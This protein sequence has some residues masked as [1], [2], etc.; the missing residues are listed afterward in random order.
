[1]Q[2]LALVQNTFNNSI[3]KVYIPDLEFC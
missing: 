2:E 1:L 3:L